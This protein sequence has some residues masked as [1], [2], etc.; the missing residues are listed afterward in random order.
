MLAALKPFIDTAQAKQFKD[1][2]E[3]ESFTIEKWLEEISAEN[4]AVARKL[5]EHLNSQ[6]ND[7]MKYQLDQYAT[8]SLI[9]ELQ[10]HP[11]GD[12][13][14]VSVMR[15]PNQKV[16]LV[17]ALLP[18][19]NVSDALTSETMTKIEKFPVSASLLERLKNNVSGSDF[20]FAIQRLQREMELT[21][22]HS[23]KIGNKDIKGVRYNYLW[24]WIH[25]SY[26]QLHLSALQHV[27]MRRQQLANKIMRSYLVPLQK[28]WP[29]DIWRQPIL[30]NSA[31]ID[32][33]RASR[34]CVGF[35]YLATDNALWRRYYQR[36]IG[37]PDLIKLRNGYNFKMAYRDFYIALLLPINKAGVTGINEELNDQATKRYRWENESRLCRRGQFNGCLPLE[38]A[39][40]ANADALVARLLKD[41]A[42]VH[43]EMAF[44][45]DLFAKR[46]LLDRS[47]MYES[48]GYV[49]T[50]LHLAVAMDNIQLVNAILNHMN[51]HPL[52]IVVDGFGVHNVNNY[53]VTPIAIAV[54]RGNIGIVN[55]LR[56]HGSVLNSQYR[57]RVS[58]LMTNQDSLLHLAV[59]SGNVE[60]VKYLFVNNETMRLLINSTGSLNMTP[61]DITVMNC[62]LEMM[63]YLVSKGAIVNAQTLPAKTL[64]LL[65]SAF[66]TNLENCSQEKFKQNKLTM[67]KFLIDHGAK[68]LITVAD[69]DGDTPLHLA[70]KFFYNIEFIKE[71][72]NNGADI[73]RPN[74]E[75]KTPYQLAEESGNECILAELRGRRVCTVM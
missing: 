40:Y 12:C 70:I 13:C 5:R 51:E 11:F 16:E 7:G 30:L 6:Q 47:R 31:P 62:D 24:D 27:H 45:R 58:A 35:N 75:G 23:L 65:C 21:R 71:L 72:L 41:G 32:L 33:G 26:N 56:K 9:N 53:Y 52:E 44:R 69:A 18:K 3:V 2:A 17:R 1:R 48:V 68:P 64:F 73:N 20:D 34:F 54:A 15:V 8:L 60:M 38:A 36:E 39:I 57:V 22:S 49:C 74:N 59:S 50:A 19:L 67:L 28:I 61:I 4:S 14:T 63:L 10:Q 43:S 66:N 42:D 25:H 55:L 46:E 37:N 29:L